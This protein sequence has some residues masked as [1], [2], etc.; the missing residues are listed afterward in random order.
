[1]ESGLGVVVKLTPK[2]ASDE[3]V[4]LERVA[5]RTVLRARVRA[6]PEKGKANAALV[7]LVAN[8]LGVPRTSVSCVAGA[9]SRLKTL[10]IAGDS[11]VL[12]AAMRARLS[13]IEE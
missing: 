5:G 7:K 6:V 2:A 12:S 4:G 9:R 10:Q 3:V 13:E 11:A 1:M 8:W